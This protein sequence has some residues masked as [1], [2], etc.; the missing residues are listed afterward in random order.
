M[1]DKEF[2]KIIKK[3]KNSVFCYYN[4]NPHNK[5]TEDCVIR[6]IAVGTGDSWENTARKL[7]EYMIQHGDMLNTPE[8][9]GKY[10]ESIGWVRQKQPV[11]SNNRKIK[12]RDFVKKNNCKA[13]ISKCNEI[14][15]TLP[16]SHLM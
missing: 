11:Y 16:T 1:N 7:T 13:I 2:E 12:V 8:L 3:L 9:Y 10:L 6:A 14:E 15:D 4:N 5:R